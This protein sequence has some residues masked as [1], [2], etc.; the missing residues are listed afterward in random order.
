MKRSILLAAIIFL[1]ACS[2]KTIPVVV[3]LDLPP[4]LEVP[5]VSADDLQCLS[6]DAYSRL[7]KRDKLKSERIR[8]LESIIESTH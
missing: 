8:T 4:P 7:V 1:T 6:N 2:V 3:R 5:S